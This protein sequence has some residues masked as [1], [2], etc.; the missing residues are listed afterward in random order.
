MRI[1]IDLFSNIDILANMQAS[2]PQ[3]LKPQV[4]KRM[5]ESVRIK[6]LLYPVKVMTAPH[7]RFYIVDGRKRVG[8]AARLGWLDVEAVELDDNAAEQ[9]LLDEIS[10]ITRKRKLFLTELVRFGLLIRAIEQHKRFKQFTESAGFERGIDSDIDSDT[11]TENTDTDIQIDTEN[12]DTDTDDNNEKTIE[13][14]GY[15]NSCKKISNLLHMSKIT[16][17]RAVYLIGNAPSEVFTQIDSR[18][19]TIG[20]AYCEVKRTTSP[21]KPKP[22]SSRS[23]API[24]RPPALPATQPPAKPHNE[25]GWKRSKIAVDKANVRIA[26]LEEKVLQEYYRANIAEGNMRD[27]KEAHHNQIY[28][29][30]GIINSLRAK[31]RE[32]QAELNS[33]SAVDR[34]INENNKSEG[35]K[36][37]GI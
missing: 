29:R 1:N 6:G 10:R 32:L 3:N 9:Y 23:A 30:D 13:H 28:H 34:N 4:T 35:I 19:K 12:T 7:G 37:N 8:A 27:L 15:K 16:F 18:R 17:S 21:P 25:S 2:K 33:Q 5:L 24:I 36:N 22:R 26:E 31:V 11:D 14:Y 20:A